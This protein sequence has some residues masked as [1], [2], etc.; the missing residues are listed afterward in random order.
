MKIL[1]AGPGTGKTTK[2]K[3]IINRDFKD[4]TVQVISFTNATIDDLTASFKSFKNVD[5]STLHSYAL[6]L[7]HLDKAQILHEEEI[8]IL[9]NLSKKTNVKFDTLCRLFDCITFDNMIKSCNDFISNNPVYAE[10]KIGKL[11]LLIVD[12]FQDFNPDEQKLIQIISKYSVETYI[13]GDDD[14]SIYSFKDADPEGIISLYNNNEIEKIPHENKCYRC[15][16]VVVDACV[17]LIS[18]NL[19]RISKVW[20]KSNRAGKLEIIQTKNQQETNDKVLKIIQDVRKIDIDGS[21]LIL[22]PVGFAAKPLVP[23]LIENGFEPNDCWNKKIDIEDLKIIWLLSAIYSHKP[24]L[25]LIFYSYTEKLFSK[26]KFISGVKNHLDKNVQSNDFKNFIVSNLNLDEELKNYFTSQPD[27]SVFKD[28]SDKYNK[29]I[30]HIDP[31]NIPH[32]LET[33][34][35]LINPKIDFKKGGINLM[36][37]HKSKGLQS[38]YV[39]ILGLVSGILPNEN[40]GLDSIEAQRRLLFVGMSRALNE[41]YIVSNIYWKAEY[42]HK[43]DSKQFKFAHWIKGPVKKYVG[44]ISSFINE[45]NK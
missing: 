39:I 38:E 7:N 28:K 10:E 26:Q 32:S 1:L 21:I 25:N 22:S 27:I 24:I 36:S 29:I 31:L 5:C 37:I 6:R 18:N 20:K 14:Q 12:E 23:M 41:L 44:Q 13:L 16:D 42:V 11:D 19:K 15:P 9:E 45:I 35:Q 8:E 30:N 4:K 17:K 33:I 43:V 40:Y 2:I 3:E 34:F